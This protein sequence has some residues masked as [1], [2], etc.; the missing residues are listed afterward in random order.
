MRWRA[1]PPL[2]YAESLPPHSPGVLTIFWADGCPRIRT[3]RKLLWE[4]S[5]FTCFNKINVTFN[6][7]TFVLH[8]L[9]FSFKYLSHLDE[10][11]A[12]TGGKSNTWRRLTLDG[13][14]LSFGSFCRYRGPDYVQQTKQ[15]NQ[16]VKPSGELYCLVLLFLLW[17]RYMQ[18]DPK[19]EICTHWSPHKM[20]LLIQE[21]WRIY[22][23][24]WPS[25]WSTDWL[26]AYYGSLC[27][28][29][30]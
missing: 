19:F 26:V 14:Y 8:L 17:W 15:Y 27:T 16:T 7:Q 20:L 12:E 28:V 21:V 18:K 9:F 11:P 24:E 13:M 1:P 25:E 23:T 5:H 30:W 2:S 4:F 29:A 6:L 22:F 10:C 3:C